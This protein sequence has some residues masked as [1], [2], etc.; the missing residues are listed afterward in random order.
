MSWIQFETARQKLSTLKGR[1]AVT[2]EVDW[3]INESQTD[4]RKILVGW[5]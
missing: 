3:G 2:K 5:G 4:G 1:G